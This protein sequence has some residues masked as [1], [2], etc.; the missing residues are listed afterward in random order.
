MKAGGWRRRSPQRERVESECASRVLR[1]RKF[2]TEEFT[3]KDTAAV[4]AMYTFDFG[5]EEEGMYDKN[6]YRLLNSGLDSKKEKKEGS[7]RRTK[8]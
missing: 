7:P 3:T 2:T 5:G 4:V 8:G 6:P 1:G